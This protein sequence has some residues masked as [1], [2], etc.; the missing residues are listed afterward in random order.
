MET[1][2]IIESFLRVLENNDYSLKAETIAD[3]SDIDQT[4]SNLQNQPM[5]LAAAE[6]KEWCIKHPEFRDA[7]L[8]NIREIKTAGSGE[9]ASTETTLFN[10]YP[11]TKSA[12]ENRQN[13]P[14][15]PADST[16]N[17]SS[18]NS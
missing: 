6:I 15:P 8:S 16:T 12:I 11:R 17:N 14:N 3:L 1:N 13:P 10:S 9:S 2:T 7:V 18:N 4:L 5:Q